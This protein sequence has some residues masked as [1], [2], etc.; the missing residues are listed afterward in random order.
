[1]TTYWCELA[2]LG[3]GAVQAEPGVAI[4]VAGDRI[5]SVA[6]GVAAAAGVVRLPGLTLP[7]LA[8]THSHAFHRALRGRTHDEGGTFW[9]W[10][11]RMYALAR[12]LDPD[13]YRALATATFAEM[14]L[15]GVSAVGEFHYL[16]HGPDGRPYADPNAMAESLREAAATAGIRITLLDTCYLHG[17]ID[18]P[19]TDVQRRFADGDADAWATRASKLTPSTGMRIGAAVH[20]VRAVDP[21][22]MEVVAAWADAHDAALHVH[23]SEQPAENEETLAALGCSPT[24]LLDR[25]GAL[26]PRTSAIHAIHVTDADIALLARSGA[27]VGVCPTT[28]RDLG[29]GI[30]PTGALRAAGVPLHLGS[31]SHAVIDLLEEARALELDERLASHERGTHYPADLLTTATANGHAALGWPEAGRL[32]A[33]AVA[34]LTTIDLG[35]VRMAGTDPRDAAGAAVFAA[36][37]SDVRHVVI[38]GEVVVRDGRHVRLDVARELDRAIR[39]VWS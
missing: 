31:D 2:W 39:A 34:D 12:R 4:E 36:T 29:D 20:S 10:R 5:A 6:L 24:A 9:T 35:S 14:A 33:G 3:D 19:P 28:E 7:G 30:G 23:V 37:A 18:R 17:G 22:A 16:H 8:N 26:G 38:G 1:V 15:A 25:H 32:V 11:D 13:T 27:F 21:A